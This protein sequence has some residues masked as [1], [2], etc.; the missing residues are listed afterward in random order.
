M[1]Y[2]GGHMTKKRENRSVVEKRTASGFGELG[3]LVGFVG[4]RMKQW[5]N[6]SKFAQIDF[7]RRVHFISDETDYVFCWQ[8]QFNDAIS[9]LT[10]RT[11]HQY[12]IK[13]EEIVEVIWENGVLGYYSPKHEGMKKAAKKFMA[14]GY[15][16]RNDARL[17]TRM[18]YACRFYVRAMK[19]NTQRGRSFARIMTHFMLS[20]ANDNRLRRIFSLPSFTLPEVGV[21]EALLARIRMELKLLRAD[22]HEFAMFNG[23]LVRSTLPASVVGRV[24]WRMLEVGDRYTIFVTVKTEQKTQ[25][26]PV[27]VVVNGFL[28]DGRIDIRGENLEEQ[29][30]LIHG[31]KHTGVLPT[32][33]SCHGEAYVEPFELEILP[34]DQS[35]E[36]SEELK[37][38][39]QRLSGEQPPQ[40]AEVPLA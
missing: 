35:S 1:Y 19:E 20:F 17:Y 18:L 24:A 7:D 34:E 36:V 21:A 29:A 16:L 11:E 22:P 10:M 14:R 30:V 26:V 6:R 3:E 12:D 8:Q 40:S 27:A 9:K 2:E 15:Y 5:W 25:R 38:L 4:K 32:D 23:K 28:P 39:K 33:F 31:E 13:P 37:Q